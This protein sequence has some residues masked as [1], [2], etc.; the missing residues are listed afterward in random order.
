MCTLNSRISWDLRNVRVLHL[1]AG[2]YLLL[3]NPVM[4]R[5]CSDSG[6]R[7]RGKRVSRAREELRVS[8]RVATPEMSGCLHYEITPTGV[9]V[10][11]L[12][13]FSLR[14]TYNFTSLYRFTL[15]ESNDGENKQYFTEHRIYIHFLR[16]MSNDTFYL[17]FCFFGFYRCSSEIKR[18]LWR[19]N[20]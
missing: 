18:F 9:I 3:P 12:L 2:T 19:F 15:R 8:R 17:C 20:C 13:S 14:Y 16:Q 5:G 1:R 7:V 4:R 6:G 11:H 10:S